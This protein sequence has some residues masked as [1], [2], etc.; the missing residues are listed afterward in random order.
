MTAYMD[1]SSVV[2]GLWVVGLALW[3][4]LTRNSHER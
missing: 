4:F 2:I 1:F 3:L